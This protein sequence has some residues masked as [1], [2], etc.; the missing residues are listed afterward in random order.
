MA[1]ARQRAR[2]AF[3]EASYSA[4]QDPK[5]LSDRPSGSVAQATSICRGQPV[6]SADSGTELTA[7]SAVRNR[8]AR[9]ARY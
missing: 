6:V 4:P 7:G 2:P 8:D 3:R 5:A 1:K 9:M